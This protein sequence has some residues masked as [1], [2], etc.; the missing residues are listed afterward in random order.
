M[1][2]RRVAQILYTAV[3]MVIR[4]SHPLPTVE[5]FLDTRVGDV[6]SEAAPDD[7]PSFWKET[8]TVVLEDLF[9]REGYRIDGLSPT[10][11]QRKNRKMRS[12]RDWIA[13]RVM[14]RNGPE[15]TKRKRG[16]SGGTSS[17]GPAGPPLPGMLSL[18]LAVCLGILGAIGLT[19]S[20]AGAATTAVLEHT[21]GDRPE[22]SRFHY[23]IL[24]SFKSQAGRTVELPYDLILDPSR[25]DLRSSGNPEEPVLIER[26]VWRGVGKKEGHSIGAVLYADLDPECG[27]TL[28]LS[29]PRLSS[30]A[31]EVERAEDTARAPSSG[32]V[33][34]VRFID[35]HASGTLDLRTLEDETDRVGL[36]FRAQLGFPVLRHKLLADAIRCR[37]SADGMLS[38]YKS[39][40][41]AH[42]ALDIDLSLS[43]LKTYT[44]PGPRPD[45]RLVHAVGLQLSPA[46]IESDQNFHIVDYT[47]AP[48]I[49]FSIPFLD[50][51]LLCWH[52][53]IEMPRGF[54]PP[55]ARVAYTFV[56]RIRDDGPNLPDR[57]RIDAEVTA[58]A[59]LLRRLDLT[60]RYRIFYDL[61]S[62]DR[63]E[64]S[65]LSWKWY[66]A[67]DTRTAVLLKLVHGALPPLFNHA[68]MVG[69][70]CEIGL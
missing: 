9:R 63:E 61:D 21:P 65:E 55:T 50:W 12:I 13:R 38:V 59:P 70:G 8:L 16:P 37:L 40:K 67:S 45:T 36:D 66:V 33:R 5:E 34:F 46:G 53:L 19:P 30:D 24:L 42:N 3:Y 49:T 57:Q 43:W 52:R 35:R 23:D 15:N 10:L 31:I 27:Y 26:V 69:V 25:Y 68:D 1:T 2:S 64:I 14:L 7:W 54:L 6:L 44:L 51:P 22:A 62:G 58:V 32:F 29:L 48:A 28:H 20:A 47:A 39:A 17:G 18:I 11:F 60:A 56:H 41:H 4:R